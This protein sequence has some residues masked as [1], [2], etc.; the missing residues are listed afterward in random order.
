MCPPRTARRIVVGAR[1]C[2]R[3]ALVA[4]GKQG[5]Q[6]LGFVGT[7]LH[8]AEI[9]EQDHLEEV[10]LAECAGQVEVA[11]GG[12]HFLDER[13]VPCFVFDHTMNTAPQRTDIPNAPLAA[14]LNEANFA[15]EYR[16][17][18]RDGLSA[19]QLR[20][21]YFRQRQQAIA[22]RVRLNAPE[23]LMVQLV[24]ALRRVLEPFID[25]ETDEI[26]HAFPTEGGN[27]S[28]LT[29]RADGLFDMEFTSSLPKFASA[30]VQAAAV[31]GIEEAN[32]LLA[33]WARGEPVRIHM[34]TVP[35]H[36]FLSDS[37]SPRDDIQLVPLALTTTQLPRLPIKSGVPTR[38]F[39][40][41]TMLTLQS[42]AS[43]ALFRPNA[44]GRKQAVQSRAADGLD[45]GFV[46]EFLSLEA[47]R[48]VCRS[49]VWHD[50]PD[51]AAFCFEIRDAW[52]LG[53]NRLKPMPWKE[54]HEDHLTGAVTITPADDVSPQRLDADH[55][56]NVLEALRRAGKS[57]RIAVD[58]WRRS[59]VPYVRPEDAY[60]DLRIALELMYLKDFANEHSQEMR[61]RLALFG[62]W[63]LSANL[64]ERKSIR[65]ALRDTYDAASKAVH[66]GEV[67]GDARVNLPDAQDLC[68]RGIFKL[69]LEGPPQDWGDLI[70]GADAR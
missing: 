22:R 43:P 67:T 70:M 55:L 66:A 49:L 12:E 69:L 31:I 62:A 10:E 64:D 44:E 42:S 32:G 13:L 5:E 59:K 50:Y 41:L 27:A 18:T 46:C 23:A 33:D 14:I 29:A 40:G 15:V 51:A 2:I 65:K 35:N 34:A 39:L 57:L 11:F 25:P 47:N 60:I 54:L 30:L 26:G 8:V 24:D 37:L 45:L 21:I 28:R 6:H 48:Y 16:K 4:L 61:F 36:L 3:A 63:H 68:R 17:T 7:L 38:N 1:A 9:V 58:R 52:S 56:R 19:A 20:E 53:D